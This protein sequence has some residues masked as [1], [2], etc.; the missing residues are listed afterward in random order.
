[1]SPTRKGQENA[2]IIIQGDEE[3]GIIIIEGKV[4]SIKGNEVSITKTF[5]VDK[6]LGVKVGDTVDLKKGSIIDSG[7]SESAIIIIQGDEERGII[8]IQGKVT[9]IKGNEVSITK[10]FKVDKVLG[11][12]VGDT[13]DLKKGA[14]AKR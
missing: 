2:I 1:M 7:G 3:R 8:I 12:K 4:T 11:V 6:V 9:S 13:V 14:L 5:K 10:T